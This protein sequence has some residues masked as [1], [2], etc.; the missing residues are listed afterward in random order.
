MSNRKIKVTF[1]LF[2]C[3]CCVLCNTAYSVDNKAHDR[4][5]INYR[6]YATNFKDSALIGCLQIAYKKIN[7]LD[8]EDL[9][10]TQRVFWPEWIDYDFDNINKTEFTI[11]ELKRLSEK[12]IEETGKLKGEPRSTLYS[13][14]CLNFYHS[15]DFDKLTKKFI[16]HPS[17][18]FKKDH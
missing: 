7:N 8:N 13:L 3:L 10:N 1:L 4:A 17:Q 14:G 5:D 6:T 2:V 18:T 15:D 11:Q 12:Y 9:R 16:I